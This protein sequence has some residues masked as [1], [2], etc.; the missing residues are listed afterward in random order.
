MLNTDI[1]LTNLFP[2]FCVSGGSAKDITLTRLLLQQ[3]G[4]TFR[5]SSRVK[6]WTL[7]INIFVMERKLQSDILALIAE[8]M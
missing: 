4:L 2:H 8:K 7:D 1:N 5:L 3:D 6:K